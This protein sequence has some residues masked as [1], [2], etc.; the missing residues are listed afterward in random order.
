MLRGVLE[1][2]GLG[3]LA[4]FIST[5]F[6]PQQ[7]NSKSKGERMDLKMRATLDSFYTKHKEQTQQIILKHYL[8]MLPSYTTQEIKDGTFW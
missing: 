1:K 5:S 6:S 2:A 8:R 3:H 4:S 7:I